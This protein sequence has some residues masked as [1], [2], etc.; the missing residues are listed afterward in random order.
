MMFNFS[1]PSNFSTCYNKYL[2]NQ[3]ET[4]A[5]HQAKL[6][7]E[8]LYNPHKNQTKLAVGVL[9]NNLCFLDVS[10]N[11]I[12]YHGLKRVELVG[13]NILT[14]QNISQNLKLNL[15]KSLKGIVHEVEEHFTT[16]N[17]LSNWTN[18]NISPWQNARGVVQGLILITKD[19]TSTKDQVVGDTGNVSIKLV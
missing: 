8:D 15:T 12:K 16:E 17:G 11:W 14:V 4:K 19:I 5:N 6:D 18:W 13:S 10:E 7:N 3:E 9:D 2:I 1:N